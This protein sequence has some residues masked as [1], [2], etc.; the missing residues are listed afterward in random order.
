MP[1]SPAFQHV[2]RDLELPDLLTQ[3]ENVE[4]LTNHP[5]WKLVLASIAAHEQRLTRQ[6]MNPTAKADDIDRLRGEIL[7]L[8][9]ARDAAE[10]ILTFAADAERAANERAAQAQE[11]ANA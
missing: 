5:G 10:T 2:I 9:S 1:T 7:G 11:Y 4:Q 8:A 6:L 3:A